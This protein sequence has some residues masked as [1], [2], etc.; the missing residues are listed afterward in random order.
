M[1]I[2]ESFFLP[3]SKNMWP[4]IILILAILSAIAI[5]FATVSKNE[6]DGKFQKTTTEGIDHVSQTSKEVL[7]NTASNRFF[8]ENGFTKYEKFFKYGYTIYHHDLN[9]DRPF[10]KAFG[11]K[12]FVEYSNASL[13]EPTE[14]NH[15]YQLKVNM[16]YKKVAGERNMSDNSIGSVINV[17][18]E[19]VGRVQMLGGI[20][21]Y[22]KPYYDF[23]DYIILLNY[24][25]PYTYAIGPQDC[26][27]FKDKEQ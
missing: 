23:C 22:G 25:K 19:S 17:S 15:N 3:K 14:E 27:Y 2:R 21:H 18:M 4:L 9:F 7:F 8:Q 20:G 12:I 13:I 24:K 10:K 16:D 11:E 26:N 6:K 1:Q 5:Y